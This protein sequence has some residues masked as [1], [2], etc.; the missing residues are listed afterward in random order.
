VVSYVTRKV[1]V[2]TIMRVEVECVVGATACLVAKL[3]RRFLTHDV[4]ENL[5][6]MYPQYWL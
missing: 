3:E 1:Y 4:M 5:D 2:T 6:V